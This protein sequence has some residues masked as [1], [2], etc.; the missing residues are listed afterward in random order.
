MTRLRSTV[1]LVLL[2]LVAAASTSFCAVALLVAMVFSSDGGSS[3]AGAL[4]SLA[5]SAAGMGALVAVPAVLA[6]LLRQRHPVASGLLT[7]LLGG[8]ITLAAGTGGIGSA[9]ALWTALVGAGLVVTSLPMPAA[10]E[11]GWGRTS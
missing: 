9:A 8:A 7:A 5:L 4:G 6:L 11:S 1:S 10:D 2:G 3:W